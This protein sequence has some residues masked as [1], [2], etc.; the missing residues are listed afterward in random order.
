[1]NLL[2][3]QSSLEIINAFPVWNTTKYNT[4]RMPRH[5]YKKFSRVKYYLE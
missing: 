5:K 2:K 4:Y 3:H 1:M